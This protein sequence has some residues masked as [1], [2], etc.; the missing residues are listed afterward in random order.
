MSG[1][2]DL[3]CHFVPGIDDGAKTPEEGVALLEALAGAGFDRVVATPHMRPGMFDNDVAALRSAFERFEGMLAGRRGIPHVSLASEHYFDDVVFRRLMNG[4]GLPYP[5]GKAVLLEFYDVE[6]APHVGARLFDL[7][8][9]RLVPVIAH[10]ERY[11]TLWRSH[12]RLA[13]LVDAGAAA[14]LDA[15]AVVGKYGKEP[16]RCARKLLDEGLYYA[17]CSDAHRASDVEDVANGIA[18]IRKRYGDEEVDHLFRQ[19]PLDILAGTVG[20]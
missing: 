18:L 19:G 1:F 11:R 3:H 15:G 8:R 13:E 2:V 20:E 7:R 9:K 10:P 4:E 16:E 14:L 12:E 5:G 17:A 6:L